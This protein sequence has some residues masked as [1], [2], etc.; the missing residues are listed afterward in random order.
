MTITASRVA[1]SAIRAAVGIGQV[2][3]RLA[4]GV[5]AQHPPTIASAEE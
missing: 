5:A 4:I 3:A 2:Q 1:A